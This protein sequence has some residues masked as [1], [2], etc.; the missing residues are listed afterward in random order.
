MALA[1]EL[2]H[3]TAAR[4]AKAF[5][6]AQDW[7]A[8]ADLLERT[9]ALSGLTIA[10]SERVLRMCTQWAGG[11]SGALSAAAND[12]ISPEH[13]GLLY[14]YQAALN[15]APVALKDAA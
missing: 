10:E 13:R 6:Y 2:P 1:T 11:L 12:C 4:E 7:K 3:E 9:A 8:S 14:R 15:A 5:T